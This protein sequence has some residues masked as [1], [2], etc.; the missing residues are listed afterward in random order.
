MSQIT[1]REAVVQSKDFTFNSDIVYIC[2]RFCI[3][4][5]KIKDGNQ[6]TLEW[7]LENQDKL[8]EVETDYWNKDGRAIM[9]P[10]DHTKYS[11]IST[12]IAHGNNTSIIKTIDFESRIASDMTKF[13]VGNCFKDKPSAESELTRLKDLQ[14]ERMEK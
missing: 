8:V 3:Y 6:V 14:K 7:F 12:E 11:Y 13:S 5:D 10:K 2:D 1:M 4:A 9:R